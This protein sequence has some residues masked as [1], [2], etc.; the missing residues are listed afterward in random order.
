MSGPHRTGIKL[1]PPLGIRDIL[2]INEDLTG[3]SVLEHAP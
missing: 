1:R 2:K 3:L